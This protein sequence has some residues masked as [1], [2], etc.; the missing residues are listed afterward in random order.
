MSES[1]PQTKPNRLFVAPSGFADKET[2]VIELPD[3][4]VQEDTSL[5]TGDNLPVKAD[6]FVAEEYIGILSADEMQAL[7]GK[8][9]EEI[10]R[11]V[12]VGAFGENVAS[13]LSDD[14]WNRIKTVPKLRAIMGE[15]K[16]KNI[17][18]TIDQ[19]QDLADR[20]M[21]VF[22]GDGERQGTPEGNIPT[23]LPTTEQAEALSKQRTGLR[24]LASN[25]ATAGKATA[26]ALT[27]PI[28][29]AKQ[30]SWKAVLHPMNQAEAWKE[31]YDNMTPAERKKYRWKVAG[32]NVAVFAGSALYLAYR[33]HGFDWMSGGGSGGGTNPHD[34]APGGGSGAPNP[35]EHKN[36]APAPEHFDMHHPDHNLDHFHYDPNLDPARDPAKHHNDWGTAPHASPEDGSNPAGYADFFG[37]RLKHSPGELS[38]TLTEFGLNGKGNVQELADQMA[39]DPKLFADKYGLLMDHLKDAKFSVITD[40]R[41]YGSYYAV[42]NPDGTV[43]V[44]YDSFVD[45]SDNLRTYGPH[46]NEFMLVEMPDGSKHYAHMGCGDQWSHF[47]TPAPR[48]APTTPVVPH[49]HA[50]SQSHYTPPTHHSTPPPPHHETPPPESTP[51]PETPPTETPPTDTPPPPPPPIA[52]KGNER[53]APDTIVPRGPARFEATPKPVETHH[54]TSTPSGSIRESITTAI[55]GDSGARRGNSQPGLSVSGPRGSANSGNVI[56]GKP[57]EP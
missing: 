23:N 42:A 12:K 13:Q 49:N 2:D 27:S 39:N 44:S 31:K 50:P 18:G 54:T 26:W 55:T 19:N 25:I 51:P 47:I 5:E 10:E 46:G 21:S 7:E 6:Q 36:D 32:A 20:L 28:D 1:Q 3:D 48:P 37:N 16:R 8:N 38:A 30:L 17:G 43:S 33:A 15:M 45:A 52:P 35:E 9:R 11:Y 4:L 34:H 40:S 14:M 22:G 41:N 57:N 56:S 29:A 24:R 53:P